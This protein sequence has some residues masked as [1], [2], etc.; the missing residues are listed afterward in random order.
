MHCDKAD[1]ELLGGSV[2][3][4]VDSCLRAAINVHK[5]IVNTG[6]A[7]PEPGALAR[8]I[9]IVV[10]VAMTYRHCGKPLELPRG[11][12]GR[13][14]KN[15]LLPDSGVVCDV[16]I[17]ECW[18]C[19]GFVSCNVGLASMS[20]GF[21]KLSESNHH[22]VGW[23]YSTIRDGVCFTQNGTTYYAHTHKMR[24]STTHYQSLHYWRLAKHIRNRD[25]VGIVI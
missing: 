5:K 13:N 16:Q 17:D 10:R 22:Y 23:R 6:A 9:P 3:A 8:S 18:I 11:P 2:T 24:Q 15:M 25:V 7:T 21:P 12:P 1:P 4:L 20:V 14:W 19:V